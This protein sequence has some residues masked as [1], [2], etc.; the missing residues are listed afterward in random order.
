MAEE[1]QK[2]LRIDRKH[3]KIGGIAPELADRC[4]TCGTCSGGC[5]ATGLVPIEGAE[6]T[7]DARKAIRAI[8]FGM[9]QEV[10]DS[11]WPWVCTLCG[12]CQNQCPMGIQLMRTFRACRTARERDKVPG[13]IHKGTMM[14]LQRGNNLGIPRD[15]FLSLLAELGVEMENDEEQPCPGFYVPVDKEGANIIVTINSKEPFGEPD[16]MKFWWRIFY[17]AKEDWTVS[18]TNWEGVN[19]GLFSG[20]DPAWKEQVGRIIENARRLKAKTILYPE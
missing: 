18:S 7:W 10:I 19:W 12:R 5:P 14:N 15:D 17:A 1:A 16:D 3:R 11:K 8:V 6:G 20:D 9:E 2:E 13:P 4:F